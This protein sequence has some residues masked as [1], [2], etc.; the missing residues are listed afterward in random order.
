MLFW[1]FWFELVWIFARCQIKIFHQNKCYIT[2]FKLLTELTLC[3]SFFFFFLNFRLVFSQPRR[4]VTVG[5]RG[6]GGS[7]VSGRGGGIR[8]GRLHLR[9]SAANPVASCFGCGCGQPIRFYSKANISLSCK[10]P[11][12]WPRTII[13]FTFAVRPLRIIECLS[14]F[15]WESTVFYFNVIVDFYYFFLHLQQMRLLQH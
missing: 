9:V 15:W 4:R 14:L 8:R 11:I 1:V 3:C 13:I 7:R 10:L 6:W 5:C 12:C 2:F